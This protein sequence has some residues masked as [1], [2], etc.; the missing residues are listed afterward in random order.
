MI[1]L[2]Y[3]LF[4][5]KSLLR[6]YAGACTRYDVHSPFLSDFIEATL[7]HKE[8][9]FLFALVDQIRNY[10]AKHPGTVNI[11]Q[12]GAPSKVNASSV[13]AVNTLVAKSAIPPRWGEFLFKTALFN[14]A[15]NILELGTNAGV[16]TL[17]LHYADRR[18]QLHTIEGNPEI[19][20]LAKRTFEVAKCHP[21]LHQYVGT[22]E[23]LLPAVLQQMRTVDLLFIDGDHRYQS[24]VHYVTECL[25]KATANSIFILADIHWSPGMEKAWE[26]VKTLPGIASSLDLGYFGVLFFQP[27]NSLPQHL[28]VIDTY[29]KPWRMGFF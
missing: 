6:W 5:F 11:L 28:K 9:Y 7:T 14:R 25:P 20:G 18:S 1:D 22:F 26:E 12:Q 13:R 10:W 23:Q 15:A 2:P 29:W 24:T 27:L 3:W 17:Y 16:S 19:A 21:T 8:P 4:R